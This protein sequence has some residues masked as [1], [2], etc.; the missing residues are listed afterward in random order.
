MTDPL[1]DDIFPSFAQPNLQ[2]PI[3]SLPQFYAPIIAHYTIHYHSKTVEYR[4]SVMLYLLLLCKCVTL[5]WA[6][7]RVLQDSYWL[8]LPVW[9]LMIHYGVP[10]MERYGRIKGEC[11]NKLL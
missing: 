11:E 7:H 6:I 4:I 10:W 3:R 2:T 9:A 1:N 8:T 5:L